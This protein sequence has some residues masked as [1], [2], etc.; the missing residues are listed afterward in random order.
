[1]VDGVKGVDQAVLIRTSMGAS[2][3]PVK[4]RQVLSPFFAV[5]L[6]RQQSVHHCDVRLH[7]SFPPGMLMSR[8]GRVA[9][10]FASRARAQPD[11]PA[12]S[13]TEDFARNVQRSDGSSKTDVALPVGVCPAGSGMEMHCKPPSSF[14]I[15]TFRSA[16]SRR[17]PRPQSRR[18]VPTTQARAGGQIR[19]AVYAGAGS[20]QRLLPW[21]TPPLY[22][23]RSRSFD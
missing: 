16:A 8:V 4:K 2:R 5:H 10:P 7:Q 17:L 1:M 3:R 23:C 20:P 13:E 6:I 12:R 11:A 19:F 15:A 21:A 18:L 9:E 14:A 22:W